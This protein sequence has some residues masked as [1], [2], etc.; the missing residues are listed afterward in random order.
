MQMKF[1]LFVLLISLPVIGIADQ[2]YEF[3]GLQLSA[4]GFAFY[5]NTSNERIVHDSYDGVVNLSLSSMYG[6]I[7]SQVSA[8]EFN[9]IRRLQLTT[10]I[11][12]EQFDQ[13]ELSVGRLT[14]PI[15]LINTS[16]SSPQLSGVLMLPL[17][18]YDPRRYQNLPDITDGAQ[19]TYTKQITDTNIKFKV[20]GGRQ[21]IDDPVFDVYGSGFSFKAESETLIGTS[22]KITHD[23]LTVKYTYTQSMGTITSTAPP[24]YINYVNPTAT[25]GIH[26]L[27]VQYNYDRLRLQS[28]ATY[29]KLNTVS[30]EMGAYFKADYNI[31]GKFCVYTGY[32]YG[33]RAEIAST[34]NDTFVGIHNTFDK[35]TVALEYHYTET[36]NWFYEY[37]KPNQNTSTLLSTIV[38]SF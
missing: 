9:H 17:S 15:G 36:N 12:T 24:T 13:V 16:S 28:E 30:D 31:Q 33:V 14:T 10:P 37:N 21:L 19:L 11:V 38:Y 35:I 25:Q 3:H 34:V 22:I 26:F 6:Y 1:K 8:N 29:R 18:T 20:Y 32:S 7:S 23:D 2:N 5:T 4:S 27:G